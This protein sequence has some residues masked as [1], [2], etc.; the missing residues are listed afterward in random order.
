MKKVL[1]SAWVLAMSSIM[2][3]QSTDEW[4][5]GQDVTS[6][7]Q[8]VDP[9]CRTNDNGSWKTT[10]DNVNLG[11][12]PCFE[13]WSSSAEQ[14]AAGTEVYQIFF[15]PAGIY[16]FHVNGFYRGEGND[17]A[18]L[19]GQYLN[20]TAVQGGQMFV[21]VGV[22]ENGKATESMKSFETYLVDFYETLTSERMWEQ[23]EEYWNDEDG[24]W[25]SSNGETM[26]YPSCQGGSN[27]RFEEG[28]CDN[29][30][31]IIQPEDGFVR[32]GVRKT[33]TAYYS[34]MYWAYFRAVYQ[35]EPSDD[36]YI[37][38]AQKA[39]ETIYYKADGSVDKYIDYMPLYVRYVDEILELGSEYIDAGTEEKYNEGVNAVKKL[40][41]TYDAYLVDATQLTALIERVDEIAQCTNLPGL[42]KFKVAIEEAKIIAFD[43]K[44]DNVD[45]FIV[46]DPSMY[47]QALSALRQAHADY[48][49]SQERLANG[50]WDFSIMIKYPFFVNWESNPTWDAE[51]GLWRFPENV[52]RDKVT[53]ENGK[54]SG[55]NWYCTDNS[56][57][58]GY[59][60]AQNAGMFCANHW[61]QQWDAH[62]DLAQDIVGLPEGYYSISGLGL[63]GMGYQT[64]QMWVNISSGDQSSTSPDASSHIGFWEGATV[65]DWM[66][67]NSGIIYVSN[68]MARVAFMDNSDNHV[69]FTGMRLFY[70]GKEPDFSLIIDPMIADT[71]NRAQTTLELSGDVKVV[72]A[73]LS[74][75]MTNVRSLEDYE[76]AL[77]FIKEAEMYIKTASDYISTHDITTLYSNL[78]DKYVMDDEINRALTTALMKSFDIYEDADATYKT[79]ETYYNDYLAYEHYMAVVSD[80]KNST[81]SETL[82]AL[83]NEQLSELVNNYKNETELVGYERALATISNQEYLS[84]LDLKS[85]SVDTPVDITALIKNANFDEGGAYWIGNADMD[86]SVQAAQAYNYD[87]EVKQTIF[88][89]PAGKYKLCMQGLYRDGTL[90][91]A[92]NKIWFDEGNF[93]ENFKM[94]ANNDSVSVVSIANMNAV[95]M[96][97][98]FTEY[99]YTVLN[100]ETGENEDLRAWIEIYEDSVA[101]KREAYDVGNVKTEIDDSGNGWLYDLSATDGLDT[102]Y[103]PNSTRGAS[104]RFKKDD[105]AYENSLIFEMSGAGDLTI[106]V[107]KNNTIEGD[108]CAFDNFR[109]YYMGSDLSSISIMKDKTFQIESICSV[110]GVLQKELKKGINIVRYT[111]GMVKKVYIK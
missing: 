44:G 35:G 39:F 24:V 66:Q 2:N 46:T 20:G 36:D 110:E 21:E 79:I 26:Y 5:V 63:G 3:A 34:T 53:I 85:A 107:I 47:G 73:I 82:S 76:Q 17:Y 16:D 68:G 75:I 104:E 99:T 70:Y 94:Y 65:S 22:D 12:G 7:L 25:T 1:L 101:Y 14:N 103:F 38:L 100:P 8:W 29:V 6:E 72:D 28:M 105:G 98:S 45:E 43:G 55:E 78:A 58:R 106:G 27:A 18:K 59:E 9:E 95:F 87:F 42:D 13:L 10:G 102:Y 88:A 96:E 86:A 61:T 93:V 71:R 91:N 60:L 31:T 90:E 37:T 84:G 54:T 33:V 19:F 108:W 74:K 80:I 56:G 64:T 50:S 89:L 111:N 97:R 51:N 11:T 77:V 48:A 57:W 23:H 4:S 109:L 49:M 67:F 41:E 92:F 83:L 30:L 81:P 62:V 52:N 69:S 32:I 15:L 40:M